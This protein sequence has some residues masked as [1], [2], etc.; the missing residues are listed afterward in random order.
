[1]S[2]YLNKNEKHLSSPLPT[3]D[4]N[5]QSFCLLLLLSR[6]STR[7]AFSHDFGTSQLPCFPIADRLLAPTRSVTAVRVHVFLVLVNSI[8]Q[9]L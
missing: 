7:E 9:E 2:P 6:L 8:E 4:S 3:V 5:G 1:M